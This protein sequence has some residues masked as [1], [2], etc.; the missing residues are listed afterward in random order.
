MEY[1][2]DPNSL[3]VTTDPLQSPADTSITDMMYSTTLS[4]LDDSTI[5]YFRVV[6]VFNEVYKRYSEVSYFRTKEPGK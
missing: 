3:D 5:Y 4:G 2:T 6:A 1:G